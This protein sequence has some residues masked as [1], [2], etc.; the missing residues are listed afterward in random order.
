LFATFLLAWESQSK[1]ALTG[2]TEMVHMPHGVA[3]LLDP[4][5]PLSADSDS[6]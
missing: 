4:M 3:P 5:T 6:A 1:K 2:L